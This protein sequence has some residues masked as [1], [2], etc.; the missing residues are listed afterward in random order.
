MIDFVVLL[1]GKYYRPEFYP[2]SVS[3]Y[4]ISWKDIDKVYGKNTGLSGYFNENG[5]TNKYSNY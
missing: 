3:G 1:I 4:D 5:I 2:R